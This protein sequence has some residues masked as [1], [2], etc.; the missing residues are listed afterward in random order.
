MSPARQ[1][2]AKPPRRG[3]E[4]ARARSRRRPRAPAIPAGDLT[5]GQLIGMG[6]LWLLITAGIVG[7]VLP[8]IAQQTA[9][10]TTL[11][12]R[13]VSTTAQALRVWSTP[14][15]RGGP[16]YHM[17]FRFTPRDHAS[18]MTDE[19][20]VSAHEAGSIRIPSSVP[21]VYDPVRPELA[22]LNN[23]DEVHRKHPRLEGVI[24]SALVIVLVLAMWSAFATFAHELLR[25]S[26]SRRP[27]T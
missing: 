1:P 19:A 7:F 14:G 17:A 2:K 20:R 27:T 15:G 12:A 10:E 18:P 23:D 11:K 9:D 6:V 21:I 24:W 8:I 25:N 22:A 3:V 5:R 16:T 13:G 26:N 4:A